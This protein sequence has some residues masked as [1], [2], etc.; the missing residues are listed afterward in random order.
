MVFWHYL[1]GYCKISVYTKCKQLKNLLYIK[2]IHKF[3]NGETKENL[4]G[5]VEI[6]PK[7]VQNWLNLADLD[8]LS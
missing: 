2:D 8:L 5:S 3:L 4:N 1:L 7:K 6:N